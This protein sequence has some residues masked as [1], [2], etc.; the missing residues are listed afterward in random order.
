MGTAWLDELRFL[1]FTDAALPVPAGLHETIVTLTEPTNCVDELFFATAGIV[2]QSYYFLT[3][4]KT[5][6]ND[7]ATCR[8]SGGW[9]AIPRST[10]QEPDFLGPSCMSTDSVCWLGGK[11]RNDVPSPQLSDYI[12]PTCSNGGCY[13]VQPTQPVDVYSDSSEHIGNWT[14]PP[15]GGVP[16]WFEVIEM[17]EDA[18]GVATG[19]GAG[20]TF[21]TDPEAW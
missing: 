21:Y 19:N 16:T 10:P 13:L 2:D 12:N 14:I 3:Q 6:W 18:G 20:S 4:T 17:I 9:P 15:G 5:Y 1:G 7:S 8:N 11:N